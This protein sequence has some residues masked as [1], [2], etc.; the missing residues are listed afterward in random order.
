MRYSEDKAMARLEI[1]PNHTRLGFVARHLGV[2][3]VRGHFN[4]FSGWV[5]GDL[6]DLDNVTGEVTVDVASLATGVG[7]RDEHLKSA[8]FFEAELYP[9]MTYRIKGA[10]KIGEDKYRVNG[11]LTIK[12]TTKPVPLEVTVEGEVPDPFGAKRRIGVSAAGQVNRMD[13]GLNWDG[14]AGAIPFASHNIKLE[15]EAALVEPAPATQQATTE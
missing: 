4:K 13:F 9:T 1:D 15:I 14:L 12:T 6:D 10:E 3:T 5:E 11:D 8:D 2:T 7:Q